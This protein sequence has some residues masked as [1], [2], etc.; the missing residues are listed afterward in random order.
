MINGNRTSGG[1]M[2]IAF[3]HYLSVF[4]SGTMIFPF[5]AFLSSDR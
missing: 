3:K 2:L 5:K 1:G 4:D